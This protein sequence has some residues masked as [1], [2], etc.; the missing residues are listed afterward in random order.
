MNRATGSTCS[1]SPGRQKK[2]QSSSKPSGAPLIPSATCGSP[3]SGRKFVNAPSAFST[4]R[5]S[6]RPRR[7]ASTIGIGSAG[8][9]LELEPARGALAGERDLQ[10][11][12]GLGDL[13]IGLLE[14]DAVPALDDPVRRGADAE[15]EA[16]AAAV[17]HRGGLL[18]EQGRA[19][20][21]DADD[22]GAEPRALGP[23]GGEGQRR[24]PVG[25]VGL[26]RPEIGVAGG[27][28]ALYEVLVRRQRQHRQ[29]QRQAPASHAGNL[30]ARAAPLV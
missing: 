7:A 26:A 13:R 30:V 18:G 21:E 6:I 28:G 8:F 14:R 5:R 1:R 25:P 9:D 29:R 4:A 20:L 10:E 27:L 24:E 11:V 15:H 23:G 17:R 3:D 19:A 2:R 16:A 12:H 22:A